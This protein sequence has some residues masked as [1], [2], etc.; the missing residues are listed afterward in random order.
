[1]FGQPQTVT[2]IVGS[3]LDAPASHGLSQLTQSLRSSGFKVT[4]RASLDAPFDGSPVVVGLC[5]APS[6]V[7][8]LLGAADLEPPVE[9]ESLLIHPVKWR[10]K[11]GLLICGHD[12][13]GL[14]YALLEVAEQ[15]KRS[16]PRPDWVAHIQGGQDRP[17]TGERGVTRMLMNRGVV[18]K[19]FYSKRYWEA[20]FNMLAR[21]RY[22]TF[23]LMFG[24]GAAGFF[25]PPYPF[26]FDVPEFPEIRVAGITKNEQQRNLEMLHTIMAMAHARGLQ[27]TVAL[28]THL[29]V[30]GHN[31]YL[32]DGFTPRKGFPVGLTEDNFI[33]YTRIALARLLDEFPGIDRVQFRVHVESS[34]V[35][36]EQKSFWTTIFDV[37]EAARPDL[38]IDMR[39]KGFTD[40]L[41]QLALDSP[42][43][44][45]LTTKFWGEEMGL[46][47]HPTQDS[48]AN[49][50]KRRHSYADLLTYPKRYQMLWRL[51]AH[52]TVKVL[53]WGDPDFARRF[54]ESLSLYDGAGFDLHEPLA[55]KMGYKR[56]L[57]DR[58]P[59]EILAPQYRSYEW[60]FQRY[61]YFYLVF[62]RLGYDPA[63]PAWVWM[64]E[65]EDRFGKKA[66]HIV[67]TAYGT[68][69]KVLPRIVAYATR[70]LSAGYSWPEKRRWEDL[71][72]YVDV[73]PSDTAQFLG[74]REA[75]RL[76]LEGKPSARIWPRENSAWFQKIC[77][78]TLELVRQAEIEAGEQK[79]SEFEAT[80]VDMRA[81]A[82]LAG[83]HARRL[84]AGMA[85]ALFEESGDRNAL[86]DAIR[87]EADAIDEWKQ[88]VAVTEDVYP[89]NI[90]MGRAPDME[91]SWKTELE[92]LLKGLREL[93]K[94]LSGYHPE[95]RKQ[96]A[97]LDFGD[98]PKEPG[99]MA[100]SSKTRYVPGQEGYGWHH[101]YLKSSPRLRK[102]PAEE[103]RDRDFL[104]GPEP[105]A[106]PYSAFGI[107]LPS[108][109][110]EL[111][112]SMV[113]QSERPADHG[114][115]W[116]VAEGRDSTDWFEVPAGESVR[117]IL[118]TTV[119]DNRLDVVFNATTDG[120][121]IIN[122]LKIDRVEP[123]I[124]H[125]PIRRTTGHEDLILRA[126]VAGPDAIRS[127]VLKYG[128]TQQYSHIDMHPTGDDTYEAVVPRSELGQGLTYFLEVTD[129]A[130]RRAWFPRSG[131]EKPISVSVTDDD[132][133]PTVEHQP[134]ERWEPG[135]PLEISAYATDASAIV[136]VRVCY[137][138]VNQH[139]DFNCVRLLP[140]GIKNDFRTE[141]PE[142][143]IDG[144]WD[145]MYF[146]EALDRFGN[147]RIYPDLES[148]TPYVIVRLH[149]Q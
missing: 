46:P 109:E 84:K 130:G 44:V 86:E 138:G 134:V 121:W 115:M 70:D 99:T 42:L 67:A 5:S 120:D 89:D 72:V 145:F 78:K 85:Y 129:A 50:Y 3:A 33:P 108:G 112:F 88:I 111:E 148:E 19:Y 71:P 136:A 127:V 128:N 37:I 81:L 9:P 135:R 118:R 43:N 17:A 47:F 32:D 16:D 52:G 35:L 6:S 82:H 87:Y 124:G 61:W 12:D 106:Y 65:F 77:D 63:T 53:L 59:Y 41:I 122:S 54:T 48:L 20:Y 98:G 31:N 18:E 142:S 93:R 62:G 140:T 131:A 80:M 4:R 38:P 91:G 28:W 75:A 51:W 116:I 68:A 119:R 27:F 11:D 114:P 39:V 132:Q 113:D 79:T 36:P 74:I 57:H 123:M 7:T 149:D 66:A 144:R 96:V 143:E 64:R 8:Q 102:G 40:D 60:E 95:Y 76:R 117:R 15:V 22:N 1:M 25:E 45:R 90:I 104:S 49:K 21:N 97:L 73:R 107:D 83:Y 13:R 146:I 10:S 105:D 110:Y 137:R 101:A 125:V 34:V 126:T 24:Y 30:P 139:Q 147:G 55:M 58:V 23:T 141:I 56:A 92:A 100:V 29:F 26:L 103:E 2:L 69:S 14:M 94:E 133:P